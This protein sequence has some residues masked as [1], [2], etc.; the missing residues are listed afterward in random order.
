MWLNGLLP[1]PA[2]SYFMRVKKKKAIHET[3]TAL[4]HSTRQ[5]EPT[6]KARSPAVEETLTGVTS[7]SSLRP[8]ASHR[9]NRAR[10]TN[11]T[12]APAQVP[13]G[14]IQYWPAA[15]FTKGW[16]AVAPPHWHRKL[17]LS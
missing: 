4:L 7:E 13:I 14:G 17:A 15:L 12:S 16:G 1:G 10:G 9:W 3:T 2:Q 6:N 8:A 11:Y 5:M